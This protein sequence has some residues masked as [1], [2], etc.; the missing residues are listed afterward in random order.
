MALLLTP[1]LFQSIDWMEKCPPSWKTRARQSLSDTLNRVWN[2]NKA[3]ERGI[4]YERAL[5]DEPRAKVTSTVPTHLLDKFNNAYEL[6]HAEGGVFQKPTKKFLDYDGKE[7][8]L[9]GKMD[10][11]F[12]DK[13]IDIKTT[14]NYKGRSSYLNSWQHKV[15]CLTSRIADF[16]FIVYEFNEDGVLHD[17]YVIDY[18]VDDFV[19]LE[20]EVM[21]KV[22]SVI[23]F[24]RADKEL[25]RAFLNKYNKYN[26]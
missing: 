22:D 8:L 3:I 18:H 19:A 4:A 7:W 14:G 9:Y 24:L 13:I 26:K 17:I 1:T 10:V 21:E 5:C 12:P 16:Q 15:Y 23:K 6:I 20:K 11:A 2:P 25:L